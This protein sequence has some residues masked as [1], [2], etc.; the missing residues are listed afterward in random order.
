MQQVIVTGADRGLGLGF[1]K[2]FLQL[3]WTVHAGQFMPDWPE[4]KE[5]QKRHPETLHLVQLD[6][7][8]DASVKAAIET[9]QSTTD[10][11][12]M[13]VN[14]AGINA[15]GEGSIRG[16]I[17]LEKSLASFNVNAVGAIRMARAVLPLMQ[18]GMKRLC[19][20]SSE[21]GSIGMCNRDAF[22]GYCMSKTAL[23]MAVRLLY[24][25]IRKDGY[26]FRLY[27][28]GWVQSYMGGKKN[29]AAHISP[30]DSAR[31]AIEQFTENRSWEDGLVMFDHEN[32]AWPF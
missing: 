28:P 29:M 22:S 30:E 19:F 20:V 15:R 17:H 26:E 11:I 16:E 21:A 1:C 31:V 10:R 3:G 27:H 13:L 32:Q 5:L 14:N 2:H 9:I 8:S 6:V 23:N 24:N 25:D 12:D 18:T 7:S 4:L